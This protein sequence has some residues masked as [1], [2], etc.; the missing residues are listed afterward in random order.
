MLKREEVI[1]VLEDI[2]TDIEN[3]YEVKFETS[4]DAMKALNNYY[5]GQYDKN[6]VIDYME[7][8][9]NEKILTDVQRVM[10]DWTAVTEDDFRLKEEISK[11]IGKDC[12]NQVTVLM[13]KPNK[14]KK[15]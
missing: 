7:K 4:E 8:L 5:K 10:R 2:R 9:R 3:G 15:K 12:S 14:T 13:V 1:A 6:I 11:I